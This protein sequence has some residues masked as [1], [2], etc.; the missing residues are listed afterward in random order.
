MRRAL[1]QESLKHH[2]HVAELL[3]R[4]ERLPGSP[5]R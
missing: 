4:A 2:G 5:T 3:E 1:Y